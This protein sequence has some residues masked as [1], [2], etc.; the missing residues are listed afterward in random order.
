MGPGENYWVQW[1]D[2][3]KTAAPADVE[4]YKA[5][6]QEPDEWQGFYEYLATKKVPLKFER[7]FD[8]IDDEP[9]HAVLAE[10]W[11]YAVSGLRVEFDQASSL[12]NWLEMTLV[13]EA[14]RV[15][16]RF[17]GVQQLTMD[18]DFP[19]ANPRIRILNTANRGWDGLKVRVESTEMGGI[20][21]WARSVERMAM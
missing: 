5:R 13:R 19:H 11:T 8:E 6:F 16:L 1:M 10:P 14:T 15:L 7:L 21:F 18:N 4:Q 2:A 9:P 20:S 12:G 17:E 3:Y